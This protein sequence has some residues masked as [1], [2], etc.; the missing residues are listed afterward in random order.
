M[1]L[2]KFELE[3]EQEEVAGRRG[4]RARGKHLEQGEGNR[5]DEKEKRIK[6]RTRRREWTK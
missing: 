4:K 2:S 3:V 1:F 6:K 5:K